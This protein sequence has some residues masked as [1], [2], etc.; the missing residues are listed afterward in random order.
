[1]SLREKARVAQVDA[2]RAQVFILQP[3]TREAEIAARNAVSSSKKARRQC[4]LADALVYRGIALAP[5]KKLGAK[6]RFA[7]SRRSCVRWEY[8][9]QAGIAALT[10]IEEI[11]QLP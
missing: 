9:N 10:A 3:S 7:G 2:T 4:F 1:V 11:K 6:I 8:I 5:N